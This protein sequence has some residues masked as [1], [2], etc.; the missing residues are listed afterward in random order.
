ME[1]SKNKALWDDVNKRVA[2]WEARHKVSPQ[3]SKLGFMHILLSH[4]APQFYSQKE[5]SQIKNFHNLVKPA[6]ARTK[7]KK[8]NKKKPKNVTP[9]ERIL[10]EE[11]CSDEGEN[12]IPLPAKKK[13]SRNAI[14]VSD[15]PTLPAPK[16]PILDDMFADLNIGTYIMLLLNY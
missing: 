4:L 10:I 7:K 8:K 9:K 12:D 1:N 5:L 15:K 14:N 11:Q 3:P 6:I 2:D 13:Y 16:L